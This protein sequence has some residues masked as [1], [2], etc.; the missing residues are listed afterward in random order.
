MPLQST[1][2]ELFDLPA[3]Y[4]QDLAVLDARW[5]ALQRQAHPDKFAAEGPAA[6]RVAAQWS[7]RINEAYRRLKDP[8]QRAAYLCELNGAPINAENNTAMPAA[9]LMQQ[10]QLREQA[11]EARSPADFDAL[12]ALA[13]QM[14]RDMQRTLEQQIDVAQDWAAAAQSVRALMFLH[15]LGDDIDRRRDAHA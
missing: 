13:R 12:E 9:F 4:S 10:M 2:F 6:Q 1:D 3:R 14:Q 11:D 5:K 7:A 8:L 15:K